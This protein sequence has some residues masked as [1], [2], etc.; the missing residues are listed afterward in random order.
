MKNIEVLKDYLFEIGPIRPPNE[1]KDCS[2]LI[3]INRYCPY[4]RCLF[5]PFYKGKKFEARKLEEIKKD[6]NAMKNLQDK[7]K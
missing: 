6:I 3:R 5:C 1:G 2:L 7:I 4:N